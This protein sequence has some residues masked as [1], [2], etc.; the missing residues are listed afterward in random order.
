KDDLQNI[1][2]NLQEID[3]SRQRYAEVER[4]ELAAY[5]QSEIVHARGVLPAEVIHQA[6]AALSGST[7][8]LVQA[9]TLL[10]TAWATINDAEAF[11]QYWIRQ[12]QQSLNEITT[13]LQNADTM[14]HH[15]GLIDNA[16][17]RQQKEAIER[18]IEEARTYL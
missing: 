13:L 18:Q 12:T 10:R 17:Y 7:D 8:E 3:Q 1:N 14:R 9:T 11:R 2:A 6:E 5:L 15:A 16:A 4:S